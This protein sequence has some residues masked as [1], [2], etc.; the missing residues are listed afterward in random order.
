[1]SS[2]I[3]SAREWSCIVFGNFALASGRRTQTGSAWYNHYHTSLQT[4]TD[5][6]ALQAQLRVYSGD[7]SDQPL[8]DDTVVFIVA[9]AYLPLRNNGPALLEAFHCY[10]YPGD[11]SDS[12]YDEQLPDI[13]VF[14]SALGIVRDC[15]NAEPQDN[16]KRISVEVGEWVREERR[17]FVVEAKLSCRTSRWTRFRL[18]AKQSIVSMYG[19]C[20]AL[21]GDGVMIIDLENITTNALPAPLADSTGTTIGPGPPPATPTAKKRKYNAFASASN[22]H[23]TPDPSRSPV[24]T[25]SGDRLE[26]PVASSSTSLARAPVAQLTDQDHALDASFSSPTSMTVSD[27]TRANEDERIPGDSNGKAAGKRR[28][29]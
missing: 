16:N 13:P 1:M 22:V 3:I 27:A 18:P 11:A 20:C 21:R 8:A 26:D 7:K 28:A 14:M 17:S 10:P 5:G 15:R 2:H 6:A 24:T 4:T 19:T 12:A 23:A 25:G 9:R 29:R